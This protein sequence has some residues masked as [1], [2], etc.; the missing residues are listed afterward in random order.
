[1]RKNKYYF[2]SITEWESSDKKE[3]K[4]LLW[5]YCG[6]KKRGMLKFEFFDNDTEAINFCRDLKMVMN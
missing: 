6:G 5:Y 4:R 2:S 1:M 3:K